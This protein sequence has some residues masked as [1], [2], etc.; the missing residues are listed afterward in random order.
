MSAV[1]VVGVGMVPFATPRN[2]APYDEMAEGAIRAA[3]TDAGLGFDAVQQVYAGFVYGDS[4]SGQRAVYRVGRT[5]IPIVNVNN[6]C[7]T[8]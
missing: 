7:S 4:T 2:A 8:G 6:N 3:L 1:H 5:G